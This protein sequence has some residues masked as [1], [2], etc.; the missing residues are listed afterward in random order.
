MGIPDLSSLLIV[1]FWSL[2]QLLLFHL[3]NDLIC[4]IL[5]SIIT[6]QE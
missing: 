2:R 3:E 4:K 1:A 6:Y 5:D